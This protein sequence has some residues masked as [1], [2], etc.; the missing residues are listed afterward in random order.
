MGEGDLG[1]LVGGLA[2]ILCRCL[3]SGTHLLLGRGLQPR[4]AEAVQGHVDVV[5]V[6]EDH[7]RLLVR[8]VIVGH[9][10]LLFYRLSLHP[11]RGDLQLALG[12]L[13]HGAQ[14]DQVDANEHVLQDHCFPVR[15]HPLSGAPDSG[16]ARSCGE[17]ARETRSKTT[18]ETCAWGLPTASSCEAKEQ[19]AD[20]FQRGD[21]EGTVTTRVLKAQSFVP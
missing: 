15:P 4:G 17:S 20:S 6:A 1:L 2:Q 11:F 9:A 14:K 21:W 16:P 3:V 13:E 7:G 18:S 12:G 19:A 5:H 8:C 10:A